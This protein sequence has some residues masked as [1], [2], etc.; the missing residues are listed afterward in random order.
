MGDYS[1]EELE[2]DYHLGNYQTCIDEAEFMPATPDSVY[3]LCLSYK[4]LNKH[5][6][7]KREIEKSISKHSDNGNVN[8]EWIFLEVLKFIAEGKHGNLEFGLLDDDER[9]RLLLSGALASSKKFSTALKLIDHFDSLRSSHA[10]IVT[11]IMMHRLDLAER[12]LAKMQRK[13]E[14]NPITE[15]TNAIVLLAN[16]QP[17]QSWRLA[18]GLSERFQPTP[19]LNNLQTASALAL[20][21]YDEA[22]KLCDASLKMNKHSVEALINMIHITS[23]SG[24]PTRKAV[25]DAYMERLRVISP[26]HAYLKELDGITSQVTKL[27]S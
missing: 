25:I 27:C 24:N 1:I 19:L 12:Q 14:Q 20:S 2:R 16:G 18:L 11:Y 21:D 13:D 3:F 10:K 17:K 4:A 23:K 5:D 8:D 26:D 7:L 22:K 15:L 6:D 9:S